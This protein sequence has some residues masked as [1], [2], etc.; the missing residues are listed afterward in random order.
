LGAFFFA[1]LAILFAF[2][3]WLAN[4]YPAHSGAHQLWRGRGSVRSLQFYAGSP[5]A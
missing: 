5:G 1:S 4:R 2:L 3:I